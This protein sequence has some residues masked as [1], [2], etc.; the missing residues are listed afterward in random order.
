[1]SWGVGIVLPVG[2]FPSILPVDGHIGVVAEL[3]G[4]EPVAVAGTVGGTAA[5]VVVRTPACIPYLFPVL[6]SC[7]VVHVLGLLCLL[8]VSLVVVHALVGGVTLGAGTPSVVPCRSILLWV[9]SV[10]VVLSQSG[11]LLVVLLCFRRC[12]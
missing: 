5:A 1:M 9:V 6:R 12:E 7:V 2:G 11:S 10:L 8:L 3:V 4:G